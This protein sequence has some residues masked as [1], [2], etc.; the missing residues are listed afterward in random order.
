MNILYIAL[1]HVI[2]KFR[3][4]HYFREII[5]F[6]NFTGN[7]IFREI[8]K[9]LINSRNLSISQKELYIYSN[10]FFCDFTGNNIFREFIKEF[11][12]SRNL[13]ISQKQLFIYIFE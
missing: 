12:K 4:Y 7:N 5:K 11:I 13:S 2:W 3:I 8:I 10:N 1:K 6:R 9:E